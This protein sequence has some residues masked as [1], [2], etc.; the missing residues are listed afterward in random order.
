MIESEHG[1]PPRKIVQPQ[2]I[3]LCLS[4]LIRCVELSDNLIR[5]E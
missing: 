2:S 5:K 3:W 4:Q 1:E